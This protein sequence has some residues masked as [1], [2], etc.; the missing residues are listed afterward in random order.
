VIEDLNVKG[1]VKNRKL[2]QAISDVSFSEFFRQME[3]KCAWYG[4]NLIRI[5]RFEASSKTCSACGAK[6]E[7]LTLADREWTCAN[8]LTS[9]DRDLN[10]AKNIKEFGLRKAGEG[11]SG[12]PVEP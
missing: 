3:Y 2:S 12:E 4:K 9:H 1:M 11:I 8:C 7:T 5:G 6:T 10:A